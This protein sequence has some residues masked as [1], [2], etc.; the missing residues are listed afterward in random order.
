MASAA[1]RKVMAARSRA[2]RGEHGH[3]VPFDGPVERLLQGVRVGHVDV[4]DVDAFLGEQR[5]QLVQQLVGHAGLELD[6]RRPC[7]RF[8]A[9][10]S[11]VW[12]AVHCGR[13]SLRRRA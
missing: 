5:C 4:A 1:G 2:D 13:P 10:A 8:G 9:A 3:V 11:H 6:L 7:G 12:H